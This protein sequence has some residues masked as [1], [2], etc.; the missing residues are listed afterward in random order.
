M[1]ITKSEEVELRRKWEDEVKAQKNAAMTTP[2]SNKPYV[3]LIV[4]MLLIVL[5]SIAAVEIFSPVGKDTTATITQIVGFGGTI[6]AGMFAFLKSTDTH[7]LV[8]SRL[9]EWMLNAEKASRADG[10]QEGRVLA[11][12]RTDQLAASTQLTAPPSPM[13]VEIVSTAEV[14]PVKII[15][16]DKPESG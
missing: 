5:L 7:Q 12:E 13:P 1:P 6:L 16:G 10:Q 2:P 9:S 8:N 4:V 3:I 14:L 11:N 15:K